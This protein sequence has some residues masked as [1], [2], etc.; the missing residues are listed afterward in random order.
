MTQAY[1]NYYQQEHLFGEPHKELITFF[2][3]QK[4]GSVLDV[5]C[6]QGRNAIALAKMGFSVA[7]ID[8]SSVGVEQ[9]L[10]NATGLNVTGVVA[11][12][13]ALSNVE[14]YDYVLFDSMFHF[15]KK[16]RKE[17]TELIL[18]TVASM[19]TGAIFVCCIQDSGDKIQVL[20]N[21]LKKAEVSE[22]L[23]DAAFV[24]VYNDASTGHSSSSNY[25]LIA[26]RK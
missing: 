20:N 12:M 9:M 24:Y 1:N 7:G 3:S 26:A 22:R 23:Q 14:Q 6:G 25:C 2:A 8:S 15:A 11:D 5:G 4:K 18:H 10:R 21:T 13:Y 19:K 17:E 16:D